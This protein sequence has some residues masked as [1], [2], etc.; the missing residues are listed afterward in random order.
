MEGG[1]DE[2]EGKEDEEVE[3][4]YRRRRIKRRH[5][6]MTDK[7]DEGHTLAGESMNH[8]G[9][10]MRRAGNGV[11]YSHILTNLGTFMASIS[12]VKGV[13]TLQH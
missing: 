13:N 12:T 1:G 3:G 8:L 11:S 7:I 6:D 4:T 5:M 9:A 10:M 2:E